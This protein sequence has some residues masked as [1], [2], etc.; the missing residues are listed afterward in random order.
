[1]NEMEMAIE[2]VYIE[3][4]FFVKEG[5]RKHELSVQEVYEYIVR[6]WIHGEVR[7]AR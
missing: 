6:H 1:M 5:P 7:A 3:N 4:K 2:P